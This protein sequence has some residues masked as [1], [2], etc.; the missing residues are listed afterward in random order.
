MSPNISYAGSSSA[1]EV[2]P[3]PFAVVEELEEGSL[4]TGALSSSTDSVKDSRELSV[5]EFELSF[6]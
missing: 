3:F 2:S 5:S 6:V 1:V 4:S